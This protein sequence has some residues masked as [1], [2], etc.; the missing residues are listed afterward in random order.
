MTSMRV[1]GPFVALLACLAP[2][3]L[4]AA[5]AI[6]VP[7]EC[8]RGPSGQTHRTSISFP[9]EVKEGETFTVRVD[10]VSS[11]TISHTG[12]NYVH[13]MT[14]E[15]LVPKGTS[16]VAGSL[17]VVPNTGSA[18][19]AGTARAAKVGDVIRLSM[20]GHVENGSSYVPPSVEWK[21]TASAAAKSKLSLQFWQYR[22]SAN[23]IFVGDVDTTCNPKPQPYTVATASVIAP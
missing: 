19:V 23:A 9:T 21:L 15:Y 7:V 17:R 2:A 22:V 1:L 6:T 10:G 3:D 11:G 4:H 13:D 18:N 5:T 12:L 16:Y 20:P 8:S 14:I